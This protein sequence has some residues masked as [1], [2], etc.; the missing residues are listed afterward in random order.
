MIVDE[1]TCHLRCRRS[2]HLK[3][4]LRMCLDEDRVDLSPCDGRLA[5]VSDAR[6]A[7]R[8]PVEENFR[9]DIVPHGRKRRIG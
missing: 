4:F 5:I 1:A 7:T 3:P 2:L 6:D 8:S 9:R